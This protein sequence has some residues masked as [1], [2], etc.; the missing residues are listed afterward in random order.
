MD[1][2][3]KLFAEKW[4]IG[5]HETLKGGCLTDVLTCLTKKHYLRQMKLLSVAINSI[6]CDFYIIVR[7]ASIV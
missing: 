3:G 5:A 7:P 1:V 2:F 4:D 6:F